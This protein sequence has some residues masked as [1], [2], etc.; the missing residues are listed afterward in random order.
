MHITAWHTRDVDIVQWMGIHVLI[1]MDFTDEALCI[2]VSVP[3][4]GT[5]RSCAAGSRSK[6]AV[7]HMEVV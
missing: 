1:K 7:P 5:T 3:K 6:W 4:G 2:L